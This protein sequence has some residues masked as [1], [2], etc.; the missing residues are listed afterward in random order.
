MGAALKRLLYATHNPGKVAE[1][2]GL[3]AK[4]GIE[5]V[6]AADLGLS[7]PEETA[8]TFEGNAKLKA[9]SAFR[10]TGVA[11]LADDSGLCVEALGGRP[12][13]HTADWAESG[14]G[15]D[16]SFAMKRVHRELLMG[17]AVEPWRAS[18][19]CVLAY[20]EDGE[21]VSFFRGEVLG[22]IVWPPRGG[23]GHGYDPIFVPERANQTFSEMTMQT[24]NSY[25][26]RSRAVQAFVES[27]FT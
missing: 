19:V 18:F 16:Y 23:A 11:A 4:N 15:R 6:S 8:D 17:S 21:Q 24:K 2:K 7:V 13:V 9:L 3:I 12:G 14:Q 5:V 25:S 26:H 20:T 22:Q 1:L 10:E 27:C